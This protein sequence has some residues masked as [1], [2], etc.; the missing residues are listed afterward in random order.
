MAPRLFKPQPGQRPFDQIRIIP[1]SRKSLDKTAGRSSVTLH[2]SVCAPSFALKTEPDGISMYPILKMSRHFTRSIVCEQIILATVLILATLVILGSIGDLTAVTIRTVDISPTP[3]SATSNSLDSSLGVASA[4]DQTF[5]QNSR[6]AWTSVLNCLSLVIAMAWLVLREQ[7]RKMR[8]PRRL[9]TDGANSVSDR[10][11]M[12]RQRTCRRLSNNTAMLMTGDIEIRQ[13]MTR[14][15]ETIRPRDT[16]E[17]ARQMFAK[18][19]TEY[20]VVSKPDG[21]LV[22]LLSRYYIARTKAKRVSDAML[23]RPFY[24]S[25]DTMLSPTVTQMLNEGVSCVA[26]VEN[27]RVIGIVTTQDIQLTFQAVLHVLSKKANETQLTEEIAA[28]L[29]NNQSILQSSSPK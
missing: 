23:P 16:M 8:S 18:Q 5:L 29:E 24:V 25:M 19:G 28:S 4:D 2:T 6:P 17:R 14:T 26:V 3:S 11:A 15:P 9:S 7:Q 12:K 22:G 10:V 1:A 13:I 20:L 27:K 21:T